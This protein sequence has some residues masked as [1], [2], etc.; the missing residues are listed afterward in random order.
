[1]LIRRE[2]WIN[3]A[4]SGQGSVCPF[5]IEGFG[6]IPM[7]VWGFFPCKMEYL[8]YLCHAKIAIVHKNDGL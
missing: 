2:S 8:V 3:W 1:M 5:L 6:E 4:Y 7:M